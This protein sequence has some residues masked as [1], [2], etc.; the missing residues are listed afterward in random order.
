MDDFVIGS[1]AD[2]SRWK[3]RLREASCVESCSPA[4][5]LKREGRCKWEEAEVKREELLQGRADAV[6]RKVGRERRASSK[7][8]RCS[9]KKA[10][11]GETASSEKGRCSWK[12]AVVESNELLPK[13]ADAL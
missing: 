3:L 8:G 11:P 9:W 10:W 12:K 4:K 5:L 2:A 6:R 13:R 1:M 7:K